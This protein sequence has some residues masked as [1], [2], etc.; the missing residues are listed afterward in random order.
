[1]GVGTGTAIAGVVSAIGSLVGGSLANHANA[2]LNKS[3]MRW[4]EAMTKWNQNWQ[5]K[6]WQKKSEE[7]PD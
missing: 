7:H 2:N 3:N 1:M 4:Q 5:E 6:M